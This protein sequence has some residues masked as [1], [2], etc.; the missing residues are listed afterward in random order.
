M[1][2]NEKK[3]ADG[4]VGVPR[5]APMRCNRIPAFGAAVGSGG[6][7]VVVAVMAVA[8]LGTTVAEGGQEPEAGKGE[9]EGGDHWLRE[10]TWNWA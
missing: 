3:D 4:D 5:L 2:G 6:A 9:E 1:V 10:T 8:R 7:E